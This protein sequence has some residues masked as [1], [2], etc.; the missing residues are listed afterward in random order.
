MLVAVLVLAAA[1]GA[2]AA[3]VALLRSADD[4]GGPVGKLSPRTMLPTVPSG[5]T[6][7][8]TTTHEHGDGGDAD[9]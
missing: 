8:P 6:T 2:I 3:N 7:P 1:G 9:D 5:P 4:S